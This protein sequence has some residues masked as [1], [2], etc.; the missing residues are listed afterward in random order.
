[1]KRC[2]VGPRYLLFWLKTASKKKKL[3]FFSVALLKIP[4]LLFSLKQLTNPGK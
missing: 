2:T 3:L 4:V 1:M